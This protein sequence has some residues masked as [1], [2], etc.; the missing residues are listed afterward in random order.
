M[1]EVLSGCSLESVGKINDIMKGTL[2][3]AAY[4]IVFTMPNLRTSIIENME[5]IACPI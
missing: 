5:P 4:D 3:K 1:K 2:N